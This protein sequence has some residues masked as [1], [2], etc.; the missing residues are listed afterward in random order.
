MEFTMAYVT[1]EKDP[2]LIFVIDKDIERSEVE[3]IKKIVD[4]MN[5]DLQDSGFSQY[6]YSVDV[7]DNKV[8]VRRNLKTL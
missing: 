5:H 2:E 6:S 1:N 4:G 7:I 3:N 8:Y